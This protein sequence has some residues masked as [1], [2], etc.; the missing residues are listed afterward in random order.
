MKIS[1]KSQK[2]IPQRCWNE[3]YEIF[4]EYYKNQMEEEVG[5]SFEYFKQQDKKRRWL[6]S[7]YDRYRC[8]ICYL[9]KEAIQ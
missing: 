4:L 9:G 6:E 8:S 2:R 1:G 3:N 7:N 5:P